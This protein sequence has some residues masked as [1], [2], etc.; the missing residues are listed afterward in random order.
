VK[1]ERLQRKRA[2]NFQKLKRSKIIFLLMAFLFLVAAC[3]GGTPPA[4]LPVKGKVPLAEEKKEG[5]A[6]E[7]EKGEKKESG[8][9][10]ETEYAYN[11]AGKSDPFKPFIQLTPTKELKGPGITPLQKYEISQLRLVAIITVPEG[12]IALVED[13]LGKGYFVRKGTVIGRN[14]GKVKKILKDRVI[15]EEVY[16]DVL[17]QT[18]VNEVYLFLHR[19]EEGGE[20]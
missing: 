19:P 17:G 5:P 3:G 15:I 2:M 14:D 11:P 12:D 18:K 7:V 13:S 8:K 6:Q 16:Q 20:S 9:K 4:S 1:R 10:E